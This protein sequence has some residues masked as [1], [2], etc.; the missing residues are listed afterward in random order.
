MRTDT[1]E[2]D[3]CSAGQH[4]D[5]ASLQAY[6]LLAKR[7]PLAVLTEQLAVLSLCEPLGKDSRD[8]VYGH[9]ARLD[10][11]SLAEMGA[12]E[13]HEVL[14]SAVSTRWPGAM[15]VSNRSTQQLTRMRNLLVPALDEAVP[16][17]DRTAAL[18]PGGG[19]TAHTSLT[20]VLVSALLHIRR[21]AVYPVWSSDVKQGLKMLALW[22]QPGFVGGDTGQYLALMSTARRLADELRTDLWTLET[23]LRRLSHFQRVGRPPYSSDDW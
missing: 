7:Q 14:S 2:P 9:A 12:K 5:C 3:R 10:P 16:I 15:Y 17:E 19:P 21:P 18:W 6:R 4:A 13:F 22:P 8:A 11:Q 20:P 1:Y 23:A